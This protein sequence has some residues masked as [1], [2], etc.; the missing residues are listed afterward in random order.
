M[1]LKRKDWRMDRTPVKKIQDKAA[2]VP[3]RERIQILLRAMEHNGMLTPAESA[4]ID[5][6][7]D[8]SDDLSLLLLLVLC[9]ARFEE[10]DITSRAVPY[11]WPLGNA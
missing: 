5:Y 6:F 8:L 10:P 3:P 1:P 7:H 2:G 11:G 4:F 9:R